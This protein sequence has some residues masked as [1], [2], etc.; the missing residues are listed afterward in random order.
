VASDL[1]TKETRSRLYRISVRQYM[2]M[3]GAGVFPETAHI[4]LLGGKLYEKMTK[5]PPHNLVVGQLGRMLGRILPE[6][7]FV[8]EEKPVK[9]GRFWYPEPD[10]AVVQGPDHRFEAKTPEA[11]DLGLVVE[12]AESSDLMDRGRKWRLHA[13]AGVSFFWIAN[14]PQRRVEVYSDPSGKGRSAAYRQAENYLDGQSIPVMIEGRQ[15]GQ[16]EVSGI[17]PNV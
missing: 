7:W 1:Q 11:A 10:I 13:S 12:V 5:Y 15:I 17:L 2:K 4:E 3:I 6:P 9:L 8:S 14:I 16:I